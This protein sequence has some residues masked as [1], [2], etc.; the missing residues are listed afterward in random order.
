[1][2]SPIF[3]VN[4]KFLSQSITGTQRFAVNIARELK[5]LQ[6][7]TLFLTPPDI[8][9]QQLA[10]ELDVKIIGSRNYRIYKKLRLPAGHLWEQFDLP[11]YLARHGYPRLLNLVNLAPYFYTNNVVTIHDIA[12]RLYPHFFSRRFALFYNFLVPRLARRARHIITVSQYSKSEICRYL[13]I[14]VSKVSVVYNAVDFHN[15]PLMQESPYPWPYI[16]SVGA[17]EPRKNISHLIAAFR[18]LPESD[19]HLVIVGAG[20]P[21]IFGKVAELS[22]GSREPTVDDNLIIFTGVLNDQE[23]V[24]LYAKA[25]VFCYPSLYEGFGLP[26]LEAQA[27]GC[28]V[29][30]SNRASLPEIF[31][32]SALYCDPENIDDIADK[33]Q[34][35]INDQQLRTNLIRNGTKNFHRF[36]WNYS[37]KEIITCV[38]KHARPE[39]TQ[40]KIYTA[41]N[42]LDQTIYTRGITKKNVPIPKVC[43]VVLNYN[44]WADTIECLESLLHNS[45][46][47]YQIVVVDNAST[48]NSVN[49]CKAWADGHLSVYVD[50]DNPLRYLSHHP[51]VTTEDYACFQ[52]AELDS[53]ESG[54]SIRAASEKIIF[55]EAEENKGY[56]AGNNIGLKWA[57]LNNSFAY[58]WILN[59][60][61]VIAHDCLVHMVACALNNHLA[62]T[63]AALWN[64]HKPLGV[65]S[66]GGHLNRFFGTSHPI[67]KK[68]ELKEKLD[69]IEGASFLISR[70][71]L[72]TIGFLP[73]EYFL[74]FEEVDYCFKARHNQLQMGTSLEATVFHK[75]GTPPEKY[76]SQ[77]TFC[78]KKGESRDLLALE[79]RILFSRKYLHNRFGLKLGLIISA[80]LRIKRKQ[81]QLAWKIIR[82][83]TYRLDLK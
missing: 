71:C 80:L 11:R 24:N 68:V 81:F 46:V 41:P 49:Y 50:P 79:N 43:I 62:I 72:E 39:F 57:A 73:E 6:P 33:L 28:P 35:L 12:F 25:A 59:N 20:S 83:T 42:R 10:T 74:F 21:K 36:N 64:Y 66:L 5:R 48:D 3:A 34:I 7:D 16:L 19:L 4:A 58:Y 15:F 40:D 54:A 23:L 70:D 31:G 1:M 63:G 44:G 14:P 26:P 32:T 47:N 22:L 45:Y 38:K 27:C 55:I 69:Y 82:K 52:Q 67:R 29:L 76:S 60:D 65:Q 18:Q 78:E 8:K 53:V 9:N 77:Q 2:S 30:V 13:L 17:L 37:A 61:T 75:A 56:A 51:T